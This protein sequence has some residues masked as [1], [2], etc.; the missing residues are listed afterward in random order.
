MIHN[1]RGCK[2]KHDQSFGAQRRPCQGPDTCES[3]SGFYFVLGT[4]WASRS[5]GTCESL[6]GFHFVLGTTWA[7]WSRDT[8]ES[9]SGFFFVLGTTWAPWSRD[10]CESLSGFY[11]VL[12]TTWAFPGGRKHI[13]YVMWRVWKAPLLARSTSSLML[14]YVS[15]K[16]V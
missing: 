8:C 2:A 10:T 9:L 12:G 5:R 7:S 16:G 1:A 4:T 15:N 11:V 3:L 13:A 14:L 6:S